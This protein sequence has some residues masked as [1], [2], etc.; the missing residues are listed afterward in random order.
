MWF[1]FLSSS[2]FLPLSGFRFLGFEEFYED[3]GNL[4]DCVLRILAVGGRERGL[5]V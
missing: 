4:E 2:F 1:R 3:D 5:Q